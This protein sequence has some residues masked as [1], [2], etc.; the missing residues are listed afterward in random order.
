MRVG[1]GMGKGVQYPTSPWYPSSSM[2]SRIIAAVSTTT[3]T[4]SALG[5]GG[6]YVHRPTH[7]A[8]THNE[9]TNHIK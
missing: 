4:G 2:R 5:I 6:A 3:C 8:S 9:Y 1:M 7:S